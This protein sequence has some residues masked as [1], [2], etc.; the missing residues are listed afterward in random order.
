MLENERGRFAQKMD[1]GDNPGMH[2]MS[3]EAQ[4]Q[5]VGVMRRRYAALKNRAQKG[6]V[7]DEVPHDRTGAQVRQRAAA[8][9]AAAAAR[10][11]GASAPVL[12]N[13]PEGP[14]QGVAERGLSA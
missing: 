2:T 9:P 4:L 1:T 12:G 8:G 6:A 13:G 5:Y 11:P 3:K 14:A 7:L 10:A